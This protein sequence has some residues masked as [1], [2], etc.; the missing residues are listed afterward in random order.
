MKIEKAQARDKKHH[1][2]QHGHK[3][4]GRSVF[5]TQAILISKANTPKKGK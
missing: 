2:A 3:V 5:L 1:K 4:S